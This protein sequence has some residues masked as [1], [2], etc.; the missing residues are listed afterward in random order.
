MRMAADP[1]LYSLDRLVESYDGRH[2]VGLRR[3]SHPSGRNCPNL[4][5]NTGPLATTT[6]LVADADGKRRVTDIQRRL[7]AIA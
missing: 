3:T 7:A 2:A 5:W 4:G 6:A 1:N